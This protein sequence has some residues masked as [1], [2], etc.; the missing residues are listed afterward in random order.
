MTPTTRVT[1]SKPLVT[2]RLYPLLL[3]LVLP[4]AAPAEPSADPLNRAL[5]IGQDTQRQLAA[6][7][8]EIEQLDD[9]TQALAADYALLQRQ[10]RQQ[11]DY[12]R[13]LR[14]T[15]ASQADKTAAVQQ[16]LSGL[17]ETRDGL[18]PLLQR[19][20]DSLAD[21]VEADLPFAVDERRRRVQRLT[22]L[23]DQL[24]IKDSEKLR[25][26]FEA[27]QVETEYGYRLEV[28][29]GP[30]PPAGGDPD[31]RE[32]DLIRI[33]RVALY[34]LSLDRHEAGIWDPRQ[35]RWQALPVSAVP[36]LEQALRIARKQTAPALLTLPLPSPT[37]SL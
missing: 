10:L 4:L 16:Q 3:G 37:D 14:A 22:T 30:L 1:T 13:R 5:E 12:L 24:D 35:R 25:R 17:D 33:G 15:A 19:M 20:R 34:Y 31:P 26:L 32:V 36:A 7:Q 6:A 21:L 27:Y 18:G 9:Q 2:H 11:R 23:L 29:R 28:T 8:T